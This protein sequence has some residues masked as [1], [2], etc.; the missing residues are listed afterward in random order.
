MRTSA[1]KLYALPALIFV[2]GSC[3]S[4]PSDDPD[5]LNFQIPAGSTLSVNEALTIP[6]GNTH[7]FIQNNQLSTQNK[8]NRYEI[9]CRL[10]FKEFGPRTIEPE[11]FRITRT[12]DSQE[13]WSYP[14]IKRFWTTVYLASDKDTDVI[15]LD[16]E[17]W[18]GGIDRNFTVT[19][20]QQSLGELITFTFPPSNKDKG[21]TDQGAK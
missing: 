15:K 3:A 19:E 10:D 6:E 14:N 1:M 18:G 16:C 4:T 17:Y 7:V 11:A 9:N 20:M 21:N 13:W 5:S 8:V 12:E 2:L